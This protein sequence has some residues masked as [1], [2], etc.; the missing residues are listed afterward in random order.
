MQ[1]TPD[2]ELVID[3]TERPECRRAVIDQFDRIPTADSDRFF[4]EGHKSGRKQDIVLDQ[5]GKGFRGRSDDFKGA[6]VAEIATNFGRHGDF[7]MAAPETGLIEIAKLVR[8]QQ[9]A[10]HSLDAPQIERKRVSALLQALPSVSRT[11]EID[12]INRYG[13]NH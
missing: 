5:N 3:L 2:R 10:F 6:N 13:I 8:L 9:L 1:T 4:N 11:R 7:A 12:D